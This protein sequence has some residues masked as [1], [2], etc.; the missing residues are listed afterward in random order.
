MLCAKLLVDGEG[1]LFVGQEGHI[2]GEKWATQ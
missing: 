1:Y 2:K